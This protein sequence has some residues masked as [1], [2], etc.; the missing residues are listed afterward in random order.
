MSHEE[1]ADPSRI[2]VETTLENALVP[3]HKIHR[4]ALGDTGAASTSRCIP[5][6]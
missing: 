2:V 5:L 1:L 6:K 4:D 3:S